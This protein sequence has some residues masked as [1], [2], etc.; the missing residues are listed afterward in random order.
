MTARAAGITV[1]LKP[2]TTEAATATARLPLLPRG[3]GATSDL[4]TLPID[5]L[6]V[7][8]LAVEILR[9][10]PIPVDRLDTIAPIP[11][12]PLDITDVP[13]RNP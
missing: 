5:P 8:P 2:D 13:R 12:A 7:A 4:D 11:V 3:F 9:P 10:D 6:D 1:R